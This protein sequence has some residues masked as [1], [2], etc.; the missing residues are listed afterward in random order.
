MLTPLDIQN[1]EFKKAFRGYSED[2]VDEFL[3]Q[4]MIDYEKLY[5]ENAELKEKIE[6]TQDQMDKYKNIEETLKN[7]LIVAQSSA[8]EVRSNATKKSELII[9]EAEQR[10]KEIL[11]NSRL[12]VE[13][14][15]Q[16][17][18]DVKKQMQIFKTRYKTLLQSQLDAVLGETENLE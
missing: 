12:E 10:A 6:K 5:K 1:K 9:E 7:T 2:E 15:K 18:E 13:K 8:E 16:E 14:V 4:I 11:Q 3:D 17:Y